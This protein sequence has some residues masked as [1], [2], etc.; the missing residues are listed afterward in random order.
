M[1]YQAVVRDATDNLVTNTNIGMQISILKGS[2]T[3]TVVYVETQ[4]PTTNANG[5]ITIEIGSG[6]GFDT[7]NWANGQYFIKTETD[8]TGGT[9]YTITGTSQLLSVPYA[10]H[11]KTAESITGTI[12]E[13]DPIF[14]ASVAA[15]ITATDTTVW[16]NKLDSEVDGSTTNEIQLLNV[17]NAGDTLSILLGN[18]VIVPGISSINSSSPIITN[19]VVTSIAS[20][21]AN[22]GYTI[23]LLVGPS[24]T[25]R[26][27]CWD[28]IVSPT[29]AGYHTTE[30]GGTGTFTSNMTGLLPNKIYYVRAYAA[31]INGTYYGSEK[32][33]SS[34][35]TTATLTTD[36]V[37][38]I[39]TTTAI[40]GGNITYI[41]GANITDRGVCWSTSQPP[42]LSNQYTTNGSGSGTF[43]S[44]L[45]GLSPNTTY[46]VRAYAINNAG[47]AYGTQK[48]LTTAFA[49]PTVVS[50]T[51]LNITAVSAI[52]HGYVSNVGSS[53]VTER[54][55]CWG[56]SPNP[57]IYNNKIALGTGTGN[58]N[59]LI[60]NLIP[61]STYHV[62][63][64]ATNSYGTSYGANK[65]F[66]SLNA[67]YEGFEN[68]MPGGSTGDWS[69]VTTNPYEGAYC[70]KATNQNDSVCLT[71]TLST[72]GNISFF[73][74]NS[75]YTYNLTTFYIDGVAQGTMSNI[76]WEQ[77]SYFF[78]SGTHTFKWKFTS[79]FSGNSAYIDKI[80]IYPY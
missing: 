52:A 47:I 13:T 75:N 53:A 7:I 1:S 29:I 39:T 37:T 76:S 17:S 6:I 56:I 19:T 71:K 31:N 25:A 42:T 4:T 24:I 44:N 55:I 32:T 77:K 78:N 46:Y 18:Y 62:R 74:A 65:A 33:F 11:S 10:L 70:L 9:N 38:A 3:G 2:A 63:A 41:G 27:V 67:F 43:T 36:N 72:A 68:G 16:N 64:F 28:T 57:I 30:T 23:S 21:T 22:C 54:G 66:T 48:S 15:S 69:I 26:G 49:L 79:Q 35:A 80:I 8:P 59:S 58:F 45:I 20:S 40:C 12:S 5:L 61:N 34:L 60:G 73:Y 14:G 51:V 50:D